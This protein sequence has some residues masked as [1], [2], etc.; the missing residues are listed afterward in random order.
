MMTIQNKSAFFKAVNMVASK[1]EAI[2]MQGNVINDRSAK[3]AMAYKVVTQLKTA[4]DFTYHVGKLFDRDAMTTL[5]KL[6]VSAGMEEVAPKQAKA[7]KPKKEQ[8][9]KTT[10]APKVPERAAKI[11]YDGYLPDNIIEN[12][13]YEQCGTIR[14]LITRY[15]DNANKMEGVHMDAARFNFQDG[16]KALENINGESYE[17]EDEKGKKYTYTPEMQLQSAMVSFFLRDYAKRMISKFL[18]MGIGYKKLN[19]EKQMENIEQKQSYM[20]ASSNR[21]NINTFS[22]DEILHELIVDSYRLTFDDEMFDDAGKTMGV[23]Y[24]RISNVLQVQTRKLRNQTKVV[25]AKKQYVQEEGASISTE[26]EALQLAEEMGIFTDAEMDIIRMRIAGYKKQEIDKKL[27]KRTDRTFNK[28][29]KSYSQ[30][31]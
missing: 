17:M 29:K 2:D 8:S 31:V 15:V 25:T 18:E 22:I 1:M 23:L 20:N 16:M 6:V 28:M 3:M 26:E 4:E 5:V 11:A 12:F 19:T 24:F 10:K 21:G 9:K 30:A 7:V 27:G 13:T 14:E